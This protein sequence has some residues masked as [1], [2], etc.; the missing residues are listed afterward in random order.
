MEL[1]EKMKPGEI[2]LF[3]DDD[4]YYFVIQKLTA[5][6]D[7]ALLRENKL[8]VTY[9]LCLDEFMSYMDGLT[10]GVELTVNEAAMKLCDPRLFT[11][12]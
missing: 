12:E 1:I 9:E 8:A 3:E 4:D 11:I 6:D 7:E 5:A 10:D 2:E